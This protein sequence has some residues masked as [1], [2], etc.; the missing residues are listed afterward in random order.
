MKGQ[1]DTAEGGRVGRV[2]EK[3]QKQEI[4]PKVE[5]KADSFAKAE[6]REDDDGEVDHW[7]SNEDGEEYEA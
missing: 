3:K 7:G 5:P 2:K 1:Q 6:V 4:Q